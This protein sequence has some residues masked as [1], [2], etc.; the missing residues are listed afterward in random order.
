M[1][2]LM[3][4]TKDFVYLTPEAAEFC[5]EQN[6]RLVGIDYITIEK[7]GDE[8]FPAHRK[9]LGNNMFVLEG[10]DLNGVPPGRY[11]LMCLPL[12]IKGGEASPARAILLQ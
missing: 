10:I 12:R 7:Y 9:I 6:S 2:R 3:N 8:F 1:R 4:V 5:V 11:T